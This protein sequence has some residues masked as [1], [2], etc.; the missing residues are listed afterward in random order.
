MSRI[1][2]VGLGRQTAGPGTK[3]TAMDYYVPVESSDA[4]VD[5]AEL[6]MEE[7]IGTRFPT[8]LVYGTR[9]FTIPFV[10]APRPAS[11]PRI[12]S[13]FV[14]QPVTTGT[15]PY[16]HVQDPTVAGKIAEWHS[17]FV[18]RKDPSP[19]IVDLMWDARGNDIALNIAPNDYLRME[20]NFIALDLDDTQSA[21]VPT[22]D[23]T[24][25]WK[26]SE[27]IAEISTDGETTWD[28]VVTAGW[29]IT[30]SN[31][32]DTDNA[33]L[34]SRKLWALPMGNADC[35]VRW[36]PRELLNDNY[37]RALFAD[38]AQIALRLTATGVDG[39]I[40]T[41]TVHECEIVT[42]PAPVSG[43]DVLKMVEITARAAQRDDGKF[44][45]FEVT[46]DVASYT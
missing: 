4:D 38:P 27:A 35:E 33:I 23:L 5:R 44:V 43:A 37:R 11:L 22:A 1:D 13:A 9:F 2:F 15:G 7:T 24:K 16:V 12:L 36:S 21:P 28:S 17:I 26:F 10:G 6:T 40:L 19:P 18:V 39:A 45:D 29:G 30:Y 14:G 3:V 32:L 20:A 42:A 31:N 34:G 41:V 8:G 25:R 46:N